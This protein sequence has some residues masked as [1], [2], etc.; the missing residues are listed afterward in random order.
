MG[1]MLLESMFVFPA[2]L[3]GVVKS[4]LVA[5]WHKLFHETVVRNYRKTKALFVRSNN[6]LAT[7]LCQNVHA[8]Y[9]M[10]AAILCAD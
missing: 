10:G 3:L 9:H 6:S 1:C 2:F 5:M 8:V 7:I 4:R